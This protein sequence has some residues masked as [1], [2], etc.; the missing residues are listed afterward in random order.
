M[1]KIGRILL[2]LWVGFN[3]LLA[4]SIVSSMLFLGTN[5]PALY[6]LFDSTSINTISPNALSTIN[7][8]AIL[9]N[10]TIAALCGLSLVVIW[11]GLLKIKWMFVS[12]WLCLGFVQL[13]GFAS[14][15][16]FGNKNLLA[17]VVSTVILEAGFLLS[18]QAL[19]EKK[20][21]KHS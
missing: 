10:S 9:M 11:K 7:G 15:T 20:K 19:R 21:G 14:D 8:L 6:I 4:L 2:Y 1:L 16:Y 13:M 3:L 17:N 5:A 12:L 18:V